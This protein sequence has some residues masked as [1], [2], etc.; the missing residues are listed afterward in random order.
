MEKAKKRLRICLFAVVAAAVVVG[1]CYFCYEMQGTGMENK[2]TL[3]S[4]VE[5][6]LRNKWQ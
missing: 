4:N 2:G 3:I 5:M 6:G 1:L